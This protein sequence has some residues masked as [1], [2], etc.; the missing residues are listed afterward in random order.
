MR[1]RGHERSLPWQF[2]VKFMLFFLILDEITTFTTNNN[3]HI[4]CDINKQETAPET[5]LQPS[6][7][8]DLSF[9]RYFCSF[10][11]DIFREIKADYIIKCNCQFWRWLDKVLNP[12]KH[13]LVLHQRQHI[14][15]DICYWWYDERKFVKIRNH[16]SSITPRPL[17]GKLFIMNHSK[18]QI[19]NKELKRPRTIFK[20]LN[21]EV[22]IV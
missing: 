18:E 10:Q 19:D 9:K 4:A 16:I 11:E 3:V 22:A 14:Y 21:A 8:V 13:V 7:V 1:E 15:A 17:L 5:M 12:C 2:T 6:I 20:S